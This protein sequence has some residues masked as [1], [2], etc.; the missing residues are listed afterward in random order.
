MHFKVLLIL[1]L[2]LAKKW[3]TRFLFKIKKQKD[4]IYVDAYANSETD[5]S[6]VDWNEEQCSNSPTFFLWDLILRIQLWILT[7]VR[8][9][10]ERKIELYINILEKLTPLFFALDSGNYARWTL[11]HV[12]DLRNLPSSVKRHFND[13]LWT[14][15]RT[16][17]KF[18]SMAIDQG[19]KYR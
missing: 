1:R 8:S 17:R 2:N 18:S 14:V 3:V 16:A 9:I 15:T 13:G 7:F 5:K 10:R 4:T 12:R 6:F 19:K 11:V